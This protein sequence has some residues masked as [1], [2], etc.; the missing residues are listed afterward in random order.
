MNT[1]QNPNQNPYAPLELVEWHGRKI[2]KR[3]YRKIQVIEFLMIVTTLFMGANDL[4]VT[5]MKRLFMV[6]NI[7][8]TVAS[9]G[10]CYERYSHCKT[11]TTPTYQ[12][13]QDLLVTATAQKQIGIAQQQISQL[14]TQYEQTINFMQ[15]DLDERHEI[16]MELNEELSALKSRKFHEQRQA[17]ADAQQAL[18]DL[19][20]V[21]DE[22]SQSEKLLIDKE[23]LLADKI[24]AFNEEQD[25]FKAD[26]WQQAQQAV[27]DQFDQLIA[28]NDALEQ[29]IGTLQASTPI[30]S[31]TREGV[32]AQRVIDLIEEMGII[33]R[34]TDYRYGGNVLTVWGTPL[35]YI[36]GNP[37]GSLNEKGVIN[38]SP[39]M[40]TGTIYTELTRSSALSIL[41]SK[42]PGCHNPV[43]LTLGRE[44]D[45]LVFTIDLSAESQAEKQAQQQFQREYHVP[46]TQDAHLLEFIKDS[47]HINLSA[48]TGR[49][50][51]TLLDFII[52]NLKKLMGDD[53]E[54]RY[55]NPKPDRRYKGIKVDFIGVDDSILGLF[56]A[57]IEIVYRVELNNDV[58]REGQNLPEHLRPAFKKY[59][60]RFYLVDEINALVGYFKSWTAK[61][62]AYFLD[63]IPGRLDLDDERLAAFNQYLKP[64][65]G[66]ASMVTDVL[67][68]VWRLGRSE[69]IKLLIAG[70]N[71]MPSQMGANVTKAD[72]LFQSMIYSGQKPIEAAYK[73]DLID[74]DFYEKCLRTLAAEKAGHIEK[75]WGTFIPMDGTAPPSIIK[76]PAP[77]SEICGIET[78]DPD[79]EM[80]SELGTGLGKVEDGLTKPAQPISSK[81]HSDSLG[82]DSDK[83]E[84]SLKPTFLEV[85]PTQPSPSTQP[86]PHDAHKVEQF[87][88]VVVGSYLKTNSIAQTIKEI[89]GLN[90]SKNRDYQV[91][92]W[93]VRL[94][95]NKSKI[96]I[97]EKVRSEDRKRD[98]MN[99]R[100]LIEYLGA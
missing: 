46:Q 77:I 91:A 99:Y 53:V 22:L 5:P 8:F 58:L 11:L 18:E 69:N 87:Y 25:Q 50:K 72:M 40:A 96:Q 66:A 37:M 42:I 32:I 44:S 23:N 15:S 84:T 19:Q 31:S 33:L 48:S 63:E 90:A 79:D 83:I 57:A 85:N 80:A 74:K 17:E 82:S 27:K 28:R 71:L 16:I 39:S 13:D 86:G 73:D 4:K 24:I 49:G 95:L 41:Q 47:L 43:E 7:T 89:W 29:I 2:N 98:A 1:S 67:K 3:D 45:Q 35:P 64:K 61:S 10:A 97:S 65:L 34:R 26:I 59:R 9:I 81:V 36:N 38:V 6:C 30:Q 51:T 94:I 68:I 100:Q 78:H 92:K 76:F 60:N 14:T 21:K 56:E 62:R 12:N 88:T 52:S 20:G 54:I 93:S 75:Y 70:Q 55:V